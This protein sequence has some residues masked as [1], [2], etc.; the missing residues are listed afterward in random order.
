MSWVALTHRAEPCEGRRTH[1]VTRGPRG[2]TPPSRE[3]T[4]TLRIGLATVVAGCL[5]LAAGA[6]ALAGSTAPVSTGTS[7]SA[8]A[9]E[10]AFHAARARQPGE[11]D[12][13]LLHARPDPRVLRAGPTDP[14]HYRRCRA[15]H[16]PRRLLR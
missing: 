4:M 15:D 1:G 14:L 16:R 12:D 3:H 13:P 9:P 6:P 2:P 5:G 11:H 10:S 8:R 7:L